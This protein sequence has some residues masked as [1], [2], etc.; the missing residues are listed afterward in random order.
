ML[1]IHKTY[2]RFIVFSVSILGCKSLNTQPE[3]NQ[4]VQL[5]KIIREVRVKMDVPGLTAAVVTSNRLSLAADGV[6]KLGDTA[7][8]TI[9]DFF[10]LGSNTKA[11]TGMLV[12]NAIDEGKLKW[13]TKVV[14]VLPVLAS[15]LLPVYNQTTIE[16]LLR[17]RSGLPP[18]TQGE[19][20]LT[21][22]QLG[23]SIMDQRLEFC[24]WVF[25]QPNVA[26]P[27]DTNIYSNAGYVV[28]A[29]MI[30]QLVNR[31]YEDLLQEKILQPIG[32]NGKYGW[33]ASQGLN[34]P[35]GHAIGQSGKLEPINPDIQDNDFPSWGTP[36]GNLS[37][38][39]E[40]YARF[41]QIILKAKKGES[42]LLTEQ[43]F[44]KILTPESGY[45]IGWVVV[46]VEG[47]KMLGHSGSA[48]SFFV[49]TLLDFEN[50]MAVAVFTNAYSPEID[51]K[52]Q[53]CAVYLHDLSL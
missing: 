39:I 28:A 18:C 5:Q 25:K 23:G 9:S 37:I 35:W 47:R 19:E 32:L 53:I 16:D 27:R 40:D 12:A 51:M 10:H 42:L 3:V 46:E 38:S 33:P 22:P 49:F 43:S 20:F 14:D 2:L 41:L 15:S 1:T 48:E 11:F 31:P 4:E 29:A 6:R 26:I 13:D 7:S 45:G 24:K 52:M 21:L 17:H 30:E 36:A 44:S 8:V 34:Q 50:D